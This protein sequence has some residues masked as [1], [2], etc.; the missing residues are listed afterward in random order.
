MKW[1]QLGAIL[2]GATQMTNTAIPIRMLRNGFDGPPRRGTRE[3]VRIAAI[4]TVN[5]SHAGMAT[6]CW[7]ASKAMNI[8][9]G[10]TQGT[11]AC[12]RKREL[13]QA[14]NAAEGQRLGFGHLSFS[15][16]RSRRRKR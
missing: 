7:I 13:Y 5:R 9:K 16:W 10:R 15:D 6:A 8:A 11:A 12:R 14:R 4:E 3:T 2:S 1:C